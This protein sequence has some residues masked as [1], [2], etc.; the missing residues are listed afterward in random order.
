MFLVVTAM[1]VALCMTAQDASLKMRFDFNNVSG[2][3]VIDDISG[4]TAKMMNSA[5]VEQMGDYNVLN[6]GNTTGYL[7][8][9]AEAG[10]VLAGLT[11]YTVSVYYLVDADASLEGNGYFLWA[12]STSDA[13][14]AGGG[15]YMAYRLNQQRFAVS[16]GGFNGEKG[17]TIGGASPKGAWIHVAY[18]QA[19]STGNLYVNGSLVQT[20]AGMPMNQSLFSTAPTY[21]WIGR[22]PFSGDN[23]LKKTLV[24]D[25]RLYNKALTAAEVETLAQETT[26]LQNAYLHGTAGDPTALLSTISQAETMLNNSSDYL[27]DAIEEL[28][29]LTIFARAAAEGSYSQSYLDNMKNQ[30][31]AMISTVRATK[32]IVLPTVTTLVEAY[33]KDRGFIHPGGLHT[34]ADFDR[35]KR[36]LAEGNEKVTAALQVLQNSEWARAGRIINPVETVIRGGAGEN[37]MA[38]A[39]AAA[40]AYQNAL[41]WKIEGNTIYAQTGVDNLMNWARVTKGVSGDSN[42]ALAAGLYGYAFAQAGELLRDY[43]GWS[44]ADFEEFRQWMLK[45]WY[46]ASINFLRGRNG[47]WENSGKWWQAPGHYWSNWGLCNVMCVVSIGILC[48]DVFIYNQGMSYFKYD[49]VG[50]FTEPPAMHSVSGHGDEYEGTQAIWNDGLTD[51]LGNLVVTDVESS[52]ETG[53]YGR[54]G[55]MNESGRD[56]GHSAMA[57]GLMVDVA[58]QGWNQGDDLFA[59][60]DHRLASGIEFTGAQTQSQENL[61]WTNYLY[62]SNGYAYTDGRSW[63]MTEP[64]MGTHI[65]PYWGTVI[66][67]YEGVKG[68]K[69]PFSEKAY[70][71][72]GIDGP[73]GGSTS[74]GYDHMGCSVLMNTRDVQL[75]PA[76]K[77]PTELSGK[78]EYSG[79]LS[80]NLI[81]SLSNERNRG[82]IN[83][84]VISHTEL[85]GLVNT[86]V[87]NNNTCVP[88]GQTLTL[89]PQLPEG[90]EDTGNWIWDTGETTKDINVS[91][92][93]SQLYRVTYTNKN[94][95]KSQQCF[96]IAVAGDCQ[97][98][99]LFP[100]ITYDGNVYNTTTIDVYYGHT[101]TLGMTASHGWGNIRWSTGQ[102]TES[103]TTAPI[104]QPREYT[105]YYTNQG[106]AVSS[107]TFHINMINSLQ[108]ITTKNGTSQAQQAFVSVGE[109]VTLSL[110][111]PSIVNPNDVVWSDGTIGDKMTI[112]DI[113]TSG[114]YTATYSVNGLPVT[115]TF[116]LYVKNPN[117]LPVAIGNYVIRHRPTGRLFTANTTDLTVSFEEGDV[118]NPQ[119]DQIWYI[120]DNGKR[121][122][123]I[124]LQDS[125]CLSKQY[126][127]LTTSQSYYFYFDGAVGIDYY[128]IRSNSNSSNWMYWSVENNGTIDTSGTLL[129][130]YPFE[131]IPV[132]IPTGIE[133]IDNV[134][135]TID[136]EVIYDLQGRRVAHPSKGFYIVNGK[137]ILI[138]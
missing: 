52:L 100:T 118:Y 108:Y 28:R 119:I 68:V 39:R 31:T 129:D 132:E 30:L 127:N 43:E 59:Y 113:Q 56:A 88:K 114:T 137:K 34:Q 115:N 69:M 136:D 73:S 134:Q 104:L 110:G 48:D 124:C 16:T 123:F 54:L 21:C 64:A 32:G 77:V 74:G 24:A 103:I 76:D 92:D 27:P 1:L 22:A 83:G 18:T 7:D 12:F 50:N 75:C 20:I 106:G 138:P 9:T 15:I 63:L 13:C 121:Y 87:V 105:V 65:R 67:I 122:S 91:T 117:K 94:G 2:S 51:F 130:A 72:M 112:T 93:R 25:F 78:M 71:A 38:A 49:Q 55:Q 26:N 86:Y 66:G 37:Y 36:Q 99:E 57:A 135:C 33:D 79:T 3:N 14:S 97:P 40:T 4:I 19:G 111:L 109:D 81:P 125:L 116:T 131:L 11:S 41:R 98:C 6:L 5:K 102:T 96:T 70:E 17:Y 82:N 133:R 84:K 23:Y 90:E 45:V 85:G 29:A 107:L 95:V 10:N 62:I 47:S 35:V 44:A 89:M 60:M 120:S 126:M 101:V 8:M 61:P 42:Y 46:P 80:T 58:K 128:A 53:A